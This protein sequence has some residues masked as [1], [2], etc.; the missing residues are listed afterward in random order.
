MFP[1]LK[2][3]ELVIPYTVLQI[4][5]LWISSLQSSKNSVESSSLF[6][7]LRLLSL[8]GCVSVHVLDFMFPKGSLPVFGD[9]Y[10]DVI[11]YLYAIVSFGHFALAWIYLFLQHWALLNFHQT[12]VAQGPAAKASKLKPE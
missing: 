3:D 2:K 8:L 12:V 10:P 5:L 4:I 1:L 9:R 11:L 7:T 6:G